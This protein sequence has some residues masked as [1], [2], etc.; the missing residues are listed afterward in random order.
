MCGG[1]GG[2]AGCLLAGKFHIHEVITV[3]RNG[4][5]NKNV[6]LLSIV[7]SLILLLPPFSIA[8]LMPSQPFFI[9][10]QLQR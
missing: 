6:E 5:S 8:F 10:S 1:G 2:M 9:A 3:P 7:K 4:I